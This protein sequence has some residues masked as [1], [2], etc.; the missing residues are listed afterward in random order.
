MLMDDL[1]EL[2]KAIDYAWERI[3][4]RILKKLNAG[5]PRTLIELLE[6]N[7]GENYYAWRTLLYFEHTFSYYC[8]RSMIKLKF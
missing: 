8:E 5:M 2:Q 4:M 6:K 1:I 3:D 7:R